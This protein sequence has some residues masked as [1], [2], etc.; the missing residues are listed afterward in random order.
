MVEKVRASMPELPADRKAR[1]VREGLTE[2]EAGVLVADRDVA[3]YFEAT[4]PGL[5]NRKSAANWVMTEVLRVARDSDQPFVEA[6]P[7]ANEVGALLQIVEAQKISLNAAKT[8]FAAMVKS[9]KGAEATIAELGLAQV[10]DESA[11][12]AACDKV[13]AA[14]PE[15]LAEY[16][17]GR[18][19]LFGF[20]VGAVMKAMGGK[21][22]PKVI[23]EVLR[24]KLAG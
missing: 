24:A 6:V 20:F 16:R 1:Y 7:P 22:N 8:A 2:Y 17:A 11:I 18:E 21:A 19:K 4:L 15:K 23:N 12:A 5:K 10:S 14:E 3:D 13:L 9:G